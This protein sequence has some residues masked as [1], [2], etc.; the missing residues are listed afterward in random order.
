VIGL[1]LGLLVARL[2]GPHDARDAGSARDGGDAAP[3]RAASLE[4]LQA[5]LDRERAERARLEAELATLREWAVEDPDA[6]EDDAEVEAAE[7]DLPGDLAPRLPAF[8]PG[9][10]EPWF[11]SDALLALGMSEIE[12]E[13]IQDRWEQLTMDQLYAK[14]QH[15]R[16]EGNLGPALRSELT[17][18]RAETRDELG[19]D[20]FD[21]MLYA[22]GQKNRVILKDLLETS[23]GWEAGLR[24]GDEVI[25]YDGER[26]F[27]PYQLR[28]YTRRGDPAALAEVRVLRDGELV[29]V[30]LPY[31]PLGAQLAF[32]QAPPYAP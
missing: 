22:T 10:E 4:A 6:E 5:E 28:M 12:V 23:P 26:V 9:S 20:A 24:P 1:V 30:F 15:A 19:D 25:S 8:D 18:L 16:G 27:A 31:G 21:A 14:D 2:L 32:S 11:R 17:R 3:S 7:G 29:R 13:R